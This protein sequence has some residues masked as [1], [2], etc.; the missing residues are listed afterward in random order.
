[1]TIFPSSSFRLE[2]IDFLRFSKAFAEVYRRLLPTVSRCDFLSA[3]AGESGMPPHLAANTIFIARMRDFLRDPGLCLIAE[4]FLFL[5]FESS[6]GDI[7]VAVAQGA[8]P[9]FTSKLSRQWL[10][11]AK[12][13]AEKEC[14]LIKQARVDLQTGLLNAYNLHTL[15]SRSGNSNRYQL[16]LIEMPPRQQG[17]SQAVR[18]VRRCAVLLKQ[19]LQ[20]EGNSLHYLDHFTFALLMH[21][22]A[23]NEGIERALVTY[24]KR[25]GCPRVSV[26]VSSVNDKEP[27]ENSGHL[28]SEALV[29]LQ[30][31]RKRGPFGFCEFSKMSYPQYHPLATPA[32]SLIRRLARKW[33]KA[34]SFSLVLFRG[35]LPIQRESEIIAQLSEGDL[36][37]DGQDLYWLLVNVAPDKAAGRVADIL[38]Q[39]NTEN[40]KMRISAGIAYYP[41]IHYTKAASIANCRKALQHASFYGEGQYALFDAT[42][43]N[44]SGDLYFSD[45][46]LTKAAREYRDG[47]KCNPDDINLHNSLG[48]TLI[49]LDKLAPAI[50]SFTR[51]LDSDQ[52]NRMAL[53]NIGQAELER[54]NCQAAYTFLVRANDC[55]D[56]EADHDQK[57]GDLLLQLGELAVAQKDYGEAVRYLLQWRKDNENCRLCGRE[58][59]A[60]GRAYMELGES[61]LAMAELQKAL[62]FD[63]FDDKAMHLLGRLYFLANEGDEIALS[64]CRKSVELM[65]SDAEYRLHL[66]IIEMRCG[67]LASAEKHLR[68]ALRKKECLSE[69]RLQLG[70]LAALRGETGRAKLWYKKVIAGDS[71]QNQRQEARVAMQRL[72]TLL[73]KNF[74]EKQETWNLN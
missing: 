38:A 28:Y 19:F 70:H 71:G 2:S 33:S 22:D 72:R 43:L 65:G 68:F 52:D 50:R 18:H 20:E 13:V 5:P 9:V 41:C 51:A 7:I 60:L 35:N 59:L 8:D 3:T 42:S 61:K 23:C 31:A 15:L 12:A 10:L 63:E 21:L 30:T 11:E 56:K 17:L 4:E 24:L 58:C 66:G 27:D 73:Q 64:L 69:A 48:V 25:E 57:S 45:G 54:K 1:L 37:W 53:Y 62:R 34:D 32:S 29:A 74:S 67:M 47:L 44:I 14:L 26:G 39:T 46:D 6:D 55:Y 40:G 16:I 36:C 49:L